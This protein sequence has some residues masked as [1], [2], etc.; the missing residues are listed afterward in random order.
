[1]VIRANTT[2]QLQSG[3]AMPRQDIAGIE[4]HRSTA[5]A[6]HGEVLAAPDQ[7]AAIPFAAIRCTLP[8]GSLER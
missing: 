1:M 8:P 7:F 5:D 2:A 3:S 4:H 6:A